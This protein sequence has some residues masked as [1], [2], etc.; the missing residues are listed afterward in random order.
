MA[1]LCTQLQ[2][3]LGTGY[4]LEREL[5]A[6]PYYLSPAWLRIAPEFAPLRG[7]PRSERLAGGTA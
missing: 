6:I 5:G 1:D 2:E 7:N 4:T 3:G